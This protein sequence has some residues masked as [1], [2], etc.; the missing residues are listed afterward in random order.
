MTEFAENLKVNAR[1]DI[2]IDHDAKNIR[3][4][5]NYFDLAITSPPYLNAVD[6]PRTHQLEMYWL[7]LATGSLVDLKRKHVG[8]EAVL[9]KD[10][11]GFQRIGVKIA[12]D[13]ISE[14]YKVD[15]R[16]AYIC[17]KYLHDMNENMKEVYRT[18][19]KGGRYV[20]VVGNN[21]VRKK[22][23]E[24]WR[25]LMSMAEDAGFSG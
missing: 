22:I 17:Y 4:R 5:D 8:T 11:K 1:V 18:L 23:F 15:P 16:R 12:D 24:T 6:Y 20:I 9:A 7:G 14:I 25:Y 13:V 21:R 19:K 10:Y 3:Y 2:P